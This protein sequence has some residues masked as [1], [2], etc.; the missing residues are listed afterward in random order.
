MAEIFISYARKDMERVLQIIQ[1]LSNLKYEYWMD[2]QSLYG[3][4][5]WAQEIPEAIEACKLLLFFL[6]ADS[7]ASDNVRREIQLALEKK[8]RIVI[9]RLDN[10]QIPLQL[11]YALAGIQW[12]NAS[13]PNLPAHIVRAV[14]GEAGPYSPPMQ[15]PNPSQADEFFREAT[16]LNLLGQ[17]ERALQLYQRVKQ[18]D[19]YYPDIDLAI[20]NI[21]RERQMGLIDR[22]GRVGLDTI[23]PVEAPSSRAW[24][25]R[26][27][28]VLGLC[29]CGLG[30]F[31]ILGLAFPAML[32]VFNVTPTPTPIISESRVSVYSA[33]FPFASTGIL[34]NA[35]DTITITAT[36]DWNCGRSATIGPD[37]YVNEQYSDTVLPAAPA[38]ALIGAV[39]ST[40]PAENIDAYF[41]VGT[42]KTWVAQE[43]GMLY[44]GCNDSIGRFA[45]NPADSKLEVLVTLEKPVNP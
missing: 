20:N 38:C 18:I 37:G 7:A 15:P 6:S 10:T 2:A 11:Q 44:L 4:E 25:S 9:V 5:L 16:R 17:A 40:A 27:A 33:S 36:G 14:E 24:L 1:G 31:L 23:K 29:V 8:R 30:A 26:Y 39:S 32:V 43:A 12:V 13:D 34:V 45:D 19:P 35:G 3:G 21:A 41:L 42:Q 22:Q 28:A